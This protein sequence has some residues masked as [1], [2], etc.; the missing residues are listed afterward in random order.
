M[1]KLER[2]LEDEW[3][4]E[5]QSLGKMQIGSE[6]YRVTVDG[7]TKLTDRLIEIKKVEIENAKESSIRAFEEDFKKQQMEDEKRDRWVKNCITIGTAV[8]GTGTAFV[9]GIMSM[10]FERE[11]TFT[12]E[13]GKGAIRQLLKFKS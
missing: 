4:Q 7:V 8:L 2:L 10:N 6:E 9:I 3:E 13:A 5:M 11:G 1:G 12:T